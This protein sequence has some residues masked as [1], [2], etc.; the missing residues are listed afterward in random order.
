[1]LLMRAWYHDHNLIISGSLFMSDYEAP[2]P[3]PSQKSSWVPSFNVF[4]KML[5]R[6]IL[7]AQGRKPTLWLEEQSSDLT[8]KYAVEIQK[9]SLATHDKAVLDT[10][11]ITPIEVE[12]IP[13]NKRRFIIKFKGNKGL[14]ENSLTEYTENALAYKA[15]VV[16]FNYRGV[17]RSQKSPSVFQDLVT[18][19]IAQVQRLL[20]AGANSENILLD[21]ESLGAGIATIVVEH[22]HN[23]GCPIYLWNSRSFSSLSVAAV[24]MT[25]PT[26]L[27]NIIKT[28]LSGLVS[29]LGWDV[30]ASSAYERIAPKYKAYMVVSKPSEK[31]KGDGAIP[32]SCSLHKAVRKKEKASDMRTGHKVYANGLF[33]IGHKDER[34][35]LVSKENEERTGQDLFGDF[36]QRLGM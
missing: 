11:D 6:F 25:V 28:L 17:A 12:G 24:N 29:A 3:Y 14:Y 23:K 26:K 20:D 16:G 10:V 31:S 32:H 9:V 21:G 2:N 35:N 22:F 5:G 18:D 4:S 30:D 33:D 36:I 7:A 15:T 19:G 13:V 1:M 34:K 27:P 8:R